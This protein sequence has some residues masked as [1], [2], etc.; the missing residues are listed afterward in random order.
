MFS[1]KSSNCFFTHKSLTLSSFSQYSLFFNQYLF[2][3][4]YSFFHLSLLPKESL[5][6][7]LSPSN[8]FFH[9]RI[10]FKQFLS[11]INPLYLLFYSCSPA[12][13]Y[14]T[15]VIL[16]SFI[17]HSF[18]P[19]RQ[20]AKTTMF[21]SGQFLYVIAFELLVLLFLSLDYI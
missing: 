11:C 5:S 13:L 16:V 14:L 15:D 10:I 12:C 3:I 8:S 6:S 17:I 7:R 19:W 9:F 20:R 21:Q 1:V 2:L 18:Y 4:F